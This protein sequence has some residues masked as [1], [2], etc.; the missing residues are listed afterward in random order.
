MVDV[1]DAASHIIPWPK[2][3]EGEHRL[4]VN[5][6]TRRSLKISRPWPPRYWSSRRATPSVSWSR[7]T[8]AEKDLAIPSPRKLSIEKLGTFHESLSTG[9]HKSFRSDGLN[10]VK[11]ANCC[12][13]PDISL[14]RIIVRTPR[15]STN[16][17]HLGPWQRDK[18]LITQY[19]WQDGI[20]PAAKFIYCSTAASPSI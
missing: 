1:L 5:W 10:L 15:Y 11:I 18:L 14:K 8:T 19:H 3:N 16:R 2:L 20:Y 17:L 6:H 9:A 13:A 7:Q 12:P 4:I